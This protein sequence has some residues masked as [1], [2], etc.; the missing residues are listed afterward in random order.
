MT[1]KGEK[2]SKKEMVKGLGKVKE[3]NVVVYTLATVYLFFD[4][5]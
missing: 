2:G 3:V 5:S 1:G 4:D